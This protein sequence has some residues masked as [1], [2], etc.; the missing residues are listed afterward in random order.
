MREVL[1]GLDAFTG[2][3]AVAF[4]AVGAVLIVR[5]PDNRL[6]WVFLAIAST[7]AG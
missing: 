5:R 1:S 2:V 3:G 6:G 4:A 7:S